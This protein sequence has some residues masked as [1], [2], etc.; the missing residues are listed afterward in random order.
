MI[1]D[2]GERSANYEEGDHTQLWKPSVPEALDSC[3]AEREGQL[4]ECW[5]AGVQLCWRHAK[6]AEG[7]L[8]RAS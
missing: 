2:D 4:A 8:Q 1:Q 6:V 7:V 5:Q 3:L